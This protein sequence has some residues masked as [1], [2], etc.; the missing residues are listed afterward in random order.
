[1]CGSRA[2]FVKIVMIARYS[3]AEIVQRTML[4]TSADKLH[5]HPSICSFVEKPKLFLY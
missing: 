4:F 1:M 5:M 2:F 3:W